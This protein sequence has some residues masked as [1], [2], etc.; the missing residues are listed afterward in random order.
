MNEAMDDEEGIEWIE[1]PFCEGTG[2]EPTLD[3]DGGDVCQNCDGDG[4]I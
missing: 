1:C 2:V 4:I 3:P